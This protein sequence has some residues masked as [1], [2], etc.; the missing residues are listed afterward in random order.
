MN[1]NHNYDSGLVG[2]VLAAFDQTQAAEAAA[3]VTANPA[4]IALGRERIAAA[5]AYLF[6]T[7]RCWQ[8]T[9]AMRKALRDLV[10]ALQ[11]V[12]AIMAGEEC[13]RHEA[14]FMK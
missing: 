5:A 8:H 4:D 3:G 11:P 13:Q 1:Y 14:M 7:S 10:R 9:E 12:P 2:E 6:S